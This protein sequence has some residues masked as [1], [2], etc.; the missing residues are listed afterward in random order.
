MGF[1]LAF[2]GLSQQFELYTPTTSIVIVAFPVSADLSPF[3]NFHPTGIAFPSG[4]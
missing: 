3:M 4:L 2:K 1:N